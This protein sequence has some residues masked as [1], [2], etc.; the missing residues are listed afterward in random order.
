MTLSKSPSNSMIFSSLEIEKKSFL[1]SWLATRTPMSEKLQ[2][3]NDS[4]LDTGTTGRFQILPNGSNR[5]WTTL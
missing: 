4:S 1:S 5:S 2:R 3:K